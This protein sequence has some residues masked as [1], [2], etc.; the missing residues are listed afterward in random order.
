ME[1]S[2]AQRLAELESAVFGSRT[3]GRPGLIET[4]DKID[5]QLAKQ[6]HILVGV[7]IGVGIGVISNAPQLFSLI[8]KIIAAL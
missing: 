1:S 2:M 7:S 3:T 4:V 5:A 8:A 6:Y